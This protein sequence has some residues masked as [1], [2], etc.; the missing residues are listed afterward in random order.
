[1]VDGKEKL[2]L[3]IS[4]RHNIKIPRIELIPKDCEHTMTV[5]AI[6]FSLNWYFF[7]VSNTIICDGCYYYEMVIWYLPADM[8]SRTARKRSL[9]MKQKPTTKVRF[10]IHSSR[11]TD[12][13]NRD[14]T[15]KKNLPE[16]K[17]PT[18]NQEPETRYSEPLEPIS[19]F[20]KQTD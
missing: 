3:K 8:D 7:S 17:P 20:N 14:P 18:Q 1:M 11:Y 16:I 12:H 10:L 15:R 4:R 2:L 9:C 6:S 13:N 5:V 19:E